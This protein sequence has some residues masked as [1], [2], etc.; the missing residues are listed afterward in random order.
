MKTKQNSLSQNSG[1]SFWKLILTIFALYFTSYNKAAAVSVIIPDPNFKAALLN[2]LSINTDANSEISF[3]EAEAVHAL[4]LSSLNITDLTGIEAFTNLTNLICSSNSLTALDVFSNTLLDTL[5]CSNNS[6]TSLNL[7]TNTQ[8]LLLDCSQNALTSIDLSQNSILN[9]LSCANN[10]ITSINLTNNINL[11]FLDCSSTTIASLNLSTNSSLESL[12]CNSNSSLTTLTVKNGNN[13]NLQIFDASNTSG[14]TCI[15]VDNPNSIGQ[16]WVKDPIAGY[17]SACLIGAIASNSGNTV[18]GL[19]AQNVIAS[20]VSVAIQYTGG[21]GGNYGSQSI[22]STG[23]LGLTA[24]ISQGVFAFGNGSL[25]ASI[26]GTP[27]SS[28]TAIFPI[29]LGGISFNISVNVTSVPYTKIRNSDCGKINLA[30]GIQ[31]ACI[32]VTGATNYEFE[33]RDLVTN[34]LI[35]TRVNTINAYTPS[36][37]GAGTLQWNTQ[38]NCRVRAKVGGI[39]GDFGLSCIIGL[40]QN[41]I[42]NGVAN[43]SLENKWCDKRNV[44]TTA[45][46][47]C[48]QVTMSYGYS[49]EFT[50]SA[51]N[52]VT[53]KNYSS[54]YLPLVQ[55]IPNLVPGHVYYVRV[56]AKSY[57]VWGNYSNICKI[58][59]AAPGS[60]YA[61][62]GDDI[63][64]DEPETSNA[65]EIE[66]IHSETFE[67]SAYPNPTNDIVIITTNYSG[68]EQVKLVVNDIS[69]RIVFQGSMKGNFNTIVDLHSFENGIYFITA[70]HENGSKKIIRIVK[71]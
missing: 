21:S 24:N 2:D 14:L 52:Q 29:T 68:T 55:V 19:L 39:W 23:V 70:M 53:I 6:I 63:E 45:T 71:N 40:G 42:V 31:V 47:T 13:A 46:I 49:F 44:S 51:T 62:S 58:A 4:N 18:N 3:P 15:E 54:R 43:T 8:L 7:G 17:S 48:T 32:A 33:F 59:L 26:T 25:N 11:T 35:L 37:V 22:A 20:N 69:G 61:Y 1:N 5:I 36:P 12:T 27:S 38:Y 67:F 57:Q 34:N 30:P 50:D 28:G 16:N 65:N 41:P 66:N 56:K 60:R 10:P 9:S 64:D